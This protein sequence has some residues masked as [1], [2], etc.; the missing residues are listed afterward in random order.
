MK[1]LLLYTLLSTFPLFLL[2]QEDVHCFGKCSRFQRVG[3][4]QRITYYQFPS[5]NKYDVKY[6]KLDISAET[7]SRVISGSASQII[8]TVSPL[9]S[10]ITELA[11]N[12]IVDSVFINGT[13][14]TFAQASDHVFIPLNT[15]YPTGVNFT[16]QIYYHGTSSNAGVFS[17][18]ISSNGLNYTATLSES[19][20]A[21]EWFPCKQ[22]LSDKI[23][24][25]DIWVT[26]S[27]I[28]KVGAN[29][30][31]QGVDALPSG[32]VRYRW[33]TTYPMNY[34][35][36][37]IAVGNY[38]EY[39]NFAKPAAIA[40][41]SI[42]V[43][44]YLV[45]NSS[46]FN[47]V[48]TNLDKTPPMLEKYS[49][50]FGLYPFYQEKYGHSMANIG[51]GMEHQT[52]STMASFGGS[53]IAHE[54]GHQWWG[55][56]VT[57]AT[58]NDIWL[59]EG[60]AS[61]CEYL[62]IEKLPLLFTTTTA[63]TWMQNFH[64]SAMSVANGSV[65]LPDASLFDENRIFSS[66]LSYNK[67]AA[68]V[69]NLRF[70]MQSDSNFFHTLQNFQTQYKDGVATATNFKNVAEATSGKNLTTFFNQWYYGEG[71][72]T[73]NITYFKPNADTI[74]LL[75]NETVSAPTITPFFGG[76]LELTITSLTGDTNIIVNLVGNNQV[77]KLAYSKL[78]NGIVVD[79][80]NWML[81][82]TGS[83]TNGIVVPV[84]I[85]SFT[86]NSSRN[87]EF[88][89]QLKTNNEIN[90]DRY[91]LEKSTDGVQYVMIQ[92]LLPTFASTNT[93]DF[94]VEDNSYN[95]CYF[96]VKVISSDGS[97]IYSSALKILSQCNPDFSVSASPIPFNENIQ[98]NI[99]LPKK[100]NVSIKLLNAIG[101]LIKKEN[102]SLMR[103]ENIWTLRNLGRLSNGSYTLQIET[104]DKTIKTI[105]IIK[106]Q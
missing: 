67:G 8:S 43:Q 90:V 84:N 27:A 23:D 72:P 12:M 102:P 58:W 50:L 16:T 26:T 46:Y 92:S 100:G 63:S 1:K 59:N 85:L 68:I 19:Y 52:M 74:L 41:D 88:K 36:P 18:S 77:F 20:Q 5:M 93:Y 31:L 22:I 29:G 99:N 71:Y 40:P 44:H 39:Q 91:E 103:G 6:L 60:F 87:C 61:Y 106:Q 86:G 97:F 48:K 28:N 7:G 3:T 47:S 70:E 32:K 10:F 2:A 82:K 79:P 25:A 35:M 51:G 21:R 11:G 62:A 94:S 89:L 101:Q 34:Y 81:N 49:E 65:Y 104:A 55:D 24:S 76:L 78:P 64:T 14:K 30:L 9:D 15:T 38:M 17:G 98:L 80:N 45:N 66:R 13:I 75:I 37:S 42:L 4:A 53:L 95:H 54:L 33:K 83:I 73:F 56:N 57:C 105:Q 96:R 69:H